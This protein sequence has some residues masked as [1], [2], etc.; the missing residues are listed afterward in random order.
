MLD[1]NKTLDIL[2]ILV[3][4]L[5]GFIGKNLI[6]SNEPNVE[7][8]Q[9][10]TSKKS[11][12]IC[13]R[14]VD[15]S[16]S[17]ESIR[18]AIKEL[19]VKIILH[20]ASSG[21]YIGEG[22]ILKK[23]I[24]M[25]ILIPIKILHALPQKSKYIYIRS[26][27]EVLN[28]NEIGNYRRKIYTLTKKFFHIY[29]QMQKKNTYSVLVGDVCGVNDERKN[30]LFHIKKSLESEN[31]VKL[32][33]AANLLFPIHVA[34]V[35]KVIG[36]IINS[37][38]EQR[39]HYLLPSQAYRIGD[40]IKLVEKILKKEIMTEYTENRIF[41]PNYQ[42]LKLYSSTEVTDFMEILREIFDDKSEIKLN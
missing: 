19:E 36:R 3:T 42:N 38:T 21:G 30:L 11:K 23:S 14:Y 2:K 29:A 39:S 9:G 33:S 18:N 27:W 40:V 7:I 22:S 6:L 37:N 35:I 5:S 12:I 4:G 41:R 34:D 26:Y 31:E 13:E 10:I 1:T 25:N 15:L 16:G 32:D 8:I 20:L 28:L 24:K 17:S